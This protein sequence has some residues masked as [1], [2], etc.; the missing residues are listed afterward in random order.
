M[1][2]GRTVSALLPP[3]DPEAVRAFRFPEVGAIPLPDP[4]WWLSVPPLAG[5]EG[6]GHRAVGGGGAAGGI[7]HPFP[8][9]TS[10]VPGAHPYAF[11]Q[12]FVHQRGCARGGHPRFNYQGCGGA[13][14]TSISGLLQP[15]VRCVEDLGVVASGHRPLHPQSLH[16]CVTF[17]DGDHPVCSPFVSSG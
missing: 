1:L 8:Q 13:C 2:A 15:C 14:S 5:L 16:G 9:S 10:T 12:P 4:F 6:Q 3:L 11:V 17:S 7:P